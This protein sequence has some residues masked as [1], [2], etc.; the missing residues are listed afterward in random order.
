MSM[1]HR[2]ACV[3]ILALLPGWLSARAAAD[4]PLGCDKVSGLPVVD[5]LVAPQ[6]LALLKQQLLIYRCQRYDSEI[7][8]VLQEAQTWIKLRAPQVSNPAVVLDID[9]TSLSN[10]KRIYQDEYYPFT[11]AC[12]FTQ[13]CSDMDWQWTEQAPAVEPVLDLYKL[14]QCIDAAS[15]CTKVDVFF[16]TG[17]HEGDKYSPKEIC[18][19]LDKCA[20]SLLRSPRD[21]TLGNL[22]KSGFKNVDDHHLFLRPKHTPGSVEP[23]VSVYKTDQRIKIEQLGKYIVANVGD[24]YSDLVG[25]HAERTFKLPNPFYFIP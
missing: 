23:T 25:L 22:Q 21:W 7:A 17:R 4:T 11:P 3:A 9:E 24:Q 1:L 5:Y 16:V 6:N 20:P 19:E 12:G 10:W 13:K 8:M 14:A 18:P 15:H 2:C